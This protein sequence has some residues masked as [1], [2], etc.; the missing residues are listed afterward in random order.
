MRL[1]R[2]KVT[3]N[4]FGVHLDQ[5]ALTSSIRPLGKQWGLTLASLVA[6]AQ[7]ELIV[8][9]P[10]VVSYGTDFV[11]RHLSLSMRTR[12]RLVFITDLSP[13]NVCQAA[14]EPA[15]LMSLAGALA[16]T[17]IRHLPRVHAK[18]F[19]ADGE[20]AIVTSGNLTTGGLRH[21]HEYGVE[22]R[23]R[24][25][26]EIVR[27]DLLELAEL[28]ASVSCESLAAYCIAAARVRESF[29]QEQRTAAAAARRQLAKALRLAE[30]DLVRMR[31]AGGAMHAVFAKTIR[32]L[33]RM[34]GPLSTEELHPLI[35]DLHPDLC[36]D[37]VD[38]VI[39]GQHFGKK[40]KHAVRT[41][42][43]QLKKR[44]FIELRQGRWFLQTQQDVT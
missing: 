17:T 19:V 7:S 30:D 36:D 18:V 43:Q 2:R 29:E 35:K 23:E 40:W 34:H 11:L 27:R 37:S 20:T 8:A 1:R 42:Q 13:K 39:D 22:L 4:R 41:A 9:S 14:T 31:L 6:S 38:R 5:Q 10:F 32:Y 28:G 26:A 24:V 12:G 21:N 25:I 16:N 15:A 33:L 3:Q 44:G